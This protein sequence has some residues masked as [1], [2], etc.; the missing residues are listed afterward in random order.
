VRRHYCAS[1]FLPLDLSARKLRN[2]ESPT[3]AR[4]RASGSAKKVLEQHEHRRRRNHRLRSY[5][6]G[7]RRHQGQRCGFATF[8]PLKSRDG[9]PLPGG[10]RALQSGGSR[11]LVP[12]KSRSQTEGRKDR[13]NRSRN[14][15]RKY[16][17]SFCPT[18]KI[19]EDRENKWRVRI[20]RIST[21]LLRKSGSARTFHLFS[22]SSDLVWNSRL[23]SSCRPFRFHLF[24]FRHESR[25]TS[26]KTR[27]RKEEARIDE[28]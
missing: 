18:L 1:L 6:A 12:R 2:S 11:G 8:V 22:L 9:S 25:D 16:E 23:A 27:T 3:S 21:L 14:S 20:S 5:G 13:R 15:D 24:D 28:S 26:N 17:S 19:K 7:D 4:S 10:I